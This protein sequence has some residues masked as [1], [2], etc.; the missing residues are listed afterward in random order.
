[1]DLTG[2]KCTSLARP[3]SPMMEMAWSMPPDSVPTYFSHFAVNSAMRCTQAT[4]P[5]LSAPCLMKEETWQQDLSVGLDAVWTPGEGSKWG[6]GRVRRSGT[7][8]GRCI[9]YAAR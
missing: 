1:M 7:A 9:W 6:V 2:L 8:L 5:Q 4:P 3:F